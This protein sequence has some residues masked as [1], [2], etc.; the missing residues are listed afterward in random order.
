ME[1]ESKLFNQSLASLIIGACWARLEGKRDGYIPPSKLTQQ[2]EDSI[3]ATPEP[4]VYDITQNGKK[5]DMQALRDICAGNLGII[6]PADRA[7]FDSGWDKGELSHVEMCDYKE[8]S[9]EL[10]EDMQC[11]LP[12]HSMKQKHGN[13]RKA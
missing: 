11:G 5:P 10:G 1:Y 3:A 12:Q 6:N 9:P 7:S 4:I 2:L 13:W 8:Y